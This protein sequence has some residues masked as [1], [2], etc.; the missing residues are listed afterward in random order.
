MA[1]ALQ[2][3]A[4]TGVKKQQLQLAFEGWQEWEMARYTA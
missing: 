2:I 3:V 4:A 1:E